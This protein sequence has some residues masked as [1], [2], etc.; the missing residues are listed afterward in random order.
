[1]QIQ[2][3]R[4]AHP[5]RR[6]N[7]RPLFARTLTRRRRRTC[8]RGRTEQG[9]WWWSKGW[10]TASTKNPATAPPR[11][12]VG[13]FCAAGRVWTRRQPGL[14]RRRAV[15]PGPPLGSP[16]PPS[17]PPRSHRREAAPLA[18]PS[19]APLLAAAWHGPSNCL[20]KAPPPPAHLHAVI[21]LYKSL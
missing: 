11:T 20:L 7:R 21:A 10:R 17:A 16:A 4:A 15:L 9:P 5:S 19:V 8:K 18:S 6:P 14:L 3:G 12:G 13:V 2:L 1:M